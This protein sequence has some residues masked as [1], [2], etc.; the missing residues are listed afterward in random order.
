[1][2]CP[3]SRARPSSS[4]KTSWTPST[5]AASPS[6]PPVRPPA[7]WSTASPSTPPTAAVACA[8]AFHSRTSPSASTPGSPRRRHAAVT[9]PSH[10]PGRVF[11]ERVDRARHPPERQTPQIQVCEARCERQDAPSRDLPQLGEQIALLHHHHLVRRHVGARLRHAP[12]RRERPP[13]SRHNHLHSP[14]V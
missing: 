1:M 5:P 13:I 4:W 6:A 7:S 8:S 10:P 11:V 3:S 12:H 2:R 14:T 9:P